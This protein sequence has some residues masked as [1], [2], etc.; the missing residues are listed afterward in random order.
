MFKHEEKT[1][2]LKDIENI[3]IGDSPDEIIASLEILTM[4]IEIDDEKE[5]LMAC[6]R[7]LTEGIQKLKDI[8]L[9]Q[10]V[11]EQFDKQ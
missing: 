2:K 8:G 6:K 9:P 3:V 4:L 7:R 11:I 1:N 10:H 5:V